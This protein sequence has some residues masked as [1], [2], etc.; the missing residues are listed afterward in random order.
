VILD[1]IFG[2]TWNELGNVS[3]F[4][5]KI[6]VCRHKSFF[7]LLVPTVMLH[8]CPPTCRSWPQKV[9]EQILQANFLNNFL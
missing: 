2:A 7:F 8:P 9:V 5:A 3:P 4:G 6:V 1:G